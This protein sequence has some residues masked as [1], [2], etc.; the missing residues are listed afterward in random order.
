[1]NEKNISEIDA[2]EIVRKINDLPNNETDKNMKISLGS[3]SIEHKGNQVF[4][5]APKVTFD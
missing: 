5:S 3:T 4:I 1:M 2:K